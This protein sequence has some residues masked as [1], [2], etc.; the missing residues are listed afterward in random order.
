MLTMYGSE[1]GLVPVGTDYEALAPFLYLTMTTLD[2]LGSDPVVRQYIHA[3]PEAHRAIRQLSTAI[4]AAGVRV[5]DTTTRH[6][7]LEEHLREFTPDEI[8]LFDL[9][10]DVIAMLGTLGG[11]SPSMHAQVLSDLR[12]LDDYPHSHHWKREVRKAGDGPEAFRDLRAHV[13][14][15]KP[16]PDRIS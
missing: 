11:L 2:L 16:H 6:G 9:A 3:A 14:R 1:R 13:P 5:R 15:H 12:S 8:W 7:F 4:A 10:I